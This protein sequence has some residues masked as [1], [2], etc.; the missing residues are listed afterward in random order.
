MNLIRDGNQVDKLVWL[1]RA[2]QQTKAAVVF[3]FGVCNLNPVL[4]VIA[5]LQQEFITTCPNS[6]KEYKISK[7]P[8]FARKEEHVGSIGMYDP[9]PPL[10]KMGIP[11]GRPDLH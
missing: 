4:E 2:P 6:C 8:D 3:V 10:Q 7:S 5:K 11:L 9:L 1:L